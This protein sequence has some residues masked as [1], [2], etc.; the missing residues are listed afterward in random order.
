MLARYRFEILK[1]FLISRPVGS[2]FAERENLSLGW[3]CQ[4]Y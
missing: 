1:G 4:S 2:C 3:E